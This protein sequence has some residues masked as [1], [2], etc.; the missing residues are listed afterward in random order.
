MEPKITDVSGA[1]PESEEVNTSLPEFPKQEWHSDVKRYTHLLCTY[2]AY[3]CYKNLI[4]LLE[5]IGTEESEAR[6]RRYKESLDYIEIEPVMKRLNHTLKRI[7][8]KGYYTNDLRDLKNHGDCNLEPG[9]EVAQ[10]LN[11]EFL[12]NLKAKTPMSNREITDGMWF[13][14]IEYTMTHNHP[15]LVAA[16]DMNELPMYAPYLDELIIE[17][18]CNLYLIAFYEKA[19]ELLANAGDNEAL[20][21]EN[22][23]LSK[24]LEKQRTMKLKAA[25]PKRAL[26]RESAE[27]ARLQRLMKAEHADHQKQIREQ[28]KKTDE[29]VE[30]YENKLAAALEEIEQLKAERDSMLSESTEGSEWNDVQLPE[31]HVVFVGGYGK[32]LLRVQELHPEWVIINDKNYRNPIPSRADLLIFWIKG[33]SHKLQE[34]VYS[35]LPESTPTCY[36]TAMNIDLLE[37]QLKE[38]WANNSSADCED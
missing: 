12:Y 6:A 5:E 35:V 9:K 15:E 18:R 24:E 3:S 20:I 1:A 33:V 16:P 21:K 17:I 2:T 22:E 10:M 29:L 37:R 13:K 31:K 36:A 27:I 25:Q 38:F 14:A 23:R 19:C 8:E 4:S 28:Q 26:K 7:K 11:L 32:L 30:K 34:Q